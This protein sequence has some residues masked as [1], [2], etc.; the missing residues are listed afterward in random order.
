MAGKGRPGPARYPREHGSP[1]GYRQHR[2][3]G[4]TPCPWCSLAQSFEDAARYQ[5]NKEKWAQARRE[6]S[7]RRRAAARAGREVTR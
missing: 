6:A 5:A 4:E 3:Y 7:A 1:R 2:Q